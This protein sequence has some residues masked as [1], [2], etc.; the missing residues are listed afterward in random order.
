MVADEVLL[1]AYAP[2]PV[3][4]LFKWYLIF[5]QPSFLCSVVFEKSPRAV[6]FPNLFNISNRKMNFL[7]FLLMF[8]IDFT[9]RKTAVTQ[10]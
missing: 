8:C 5:A 1:R 9:L 2:I 7:F 6:L 10:G 3:L 4:S